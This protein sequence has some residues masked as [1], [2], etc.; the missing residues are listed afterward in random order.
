MGDYPERAQ[1][2]L[3]E[4]RAIIFC[5]AARLAKVGPICE[6]T[7]WGEPAYLTQETGVGST[8]RVAWKKRTPGEI[9]LYFNCQTTLVDSFRTL[10]PEL[11]FEGNS[12][13]KL[14]L[15][16][17]LPADELALCAEAALTY[18]IRKKTAKKRQASKR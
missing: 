2:K 10:F 17:A 1:A 4:I 6:C 9:G 11:R 13:L 5:T 7:K 8:I 15:D 18:H 16:E 3:L 14:A 12:A